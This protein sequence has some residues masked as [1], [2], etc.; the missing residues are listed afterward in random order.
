MQVGD[1]VQPKASLEDYASWDEDECWVGVVLDRVDDAKAE[2]YV[3]VYWNTDFSREEEYVSSMEV[4]SA[5]R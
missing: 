5:S 1:L 4:I 2:P 3:V